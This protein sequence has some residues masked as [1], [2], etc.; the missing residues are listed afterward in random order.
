[1]NYPLIM[2]NIRLLFLTV[3]FA[4]LVFMMP[5]TALAADLDQGA[6]LFSA[7]CAVCHIGGGN[8]IMSIKT[9]KQDALEKFLAGYGS[10]HNQDALTKQI[11]YGKGMMPAFKNRLSNE[12]IAS[13]A[14]YVQSQ[15]ENGWVR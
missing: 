8:S 2:R 3:L 7:N 5:E 6:Q 10:A 14:A 13:V 4:V 12:Q 15:A 1:M 11:T 9:L